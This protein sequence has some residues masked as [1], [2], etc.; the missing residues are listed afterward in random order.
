MLR[1]HPRAVRRCWPIISAL[2]PLNYQT[3][4]CR[5]V[6]EPS[7]TRLDL[8]ELAETQEAGP[9][10]LNILRVLDIPQ[11]VAI[12]A[13]RSPVRPH[14]SQAQGWDFPASVARALH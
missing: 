7:I 1:K 4:A 14:Q 8:W 6:F 9:D 3:H 5:A 13:E 12:A 2:R 11:A 10:Y